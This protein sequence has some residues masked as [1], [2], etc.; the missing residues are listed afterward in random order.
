MLHENSPATCPSAIRVISVPVP[1]GRLYRDLTVQLRAMYDD[2]LSEPLPAQL[3]ARAGLCQ[4][5]APTLYTREMSDG[6]AT[7][8]SGVDR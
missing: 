8:A 5:G 3:I 2:L 6:A 7:I 1:T 4:N